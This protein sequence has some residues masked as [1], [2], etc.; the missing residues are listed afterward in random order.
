MLLQREIWVG[1]VKHFKCFFRQL[2][3]FV[4][5]ICMLLFLKDVAEGFAFTAMTREISYVWQ[6]SVGV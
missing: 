5:K 6:E 3:H 4:N 1:G 2:Y